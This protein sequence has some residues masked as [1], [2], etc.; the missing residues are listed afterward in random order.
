MTEDGKWLM[1]AHRTA[2]ATGLAVPCKLV[3][4]GLHVIGCL[5]HETSGSKNNRHRLPP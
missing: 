2:Q 5:P 3:C 1:D 4:G